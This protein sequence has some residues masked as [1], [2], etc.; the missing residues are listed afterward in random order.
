MI[1]NR[2]SPASPVCAAQG[3]HGE[4]IIVQGNGVKP[5]RW[6]G[7][8]VA[9]DAGVI[10]P[11][12][13]LDVA[14]DSVP[15]GM[16]EGD[17]P[18]PVKPTPGRSEVPESPGTL[19]RITVDGKRHYYVARTDVYKAGNV[20]YGPPELTYSTSEPI[21]NG[22]GR[23]AE[24]KAF[25]NQSSLSE[26]RVDDGGKYYPVAPSI[27]LSDTHGKNAVLKAILDAPEQIEDPAN[28]R[29]TGITGYSE[30]SST[31]W[32]DEATYIEADK[33]RYG[34][35]KFVDIPLE[36]G[37]HQIMGPSF[38]YSVE[39]GCVDRD[40]NP[41]Y[42]WFQIAAQ[43]SVTISGI[44]E[45]R[46]A[47]LRVNAIGWAYNG[48]TCDE[49]RYNRT[50]GCSSSC[51]FYYYLASGAGS[52]VAKKFGAGYNAEDDIIIRIHGIATFDAQ[53]G[54]WERPSPPEKDIVIRA[55]QGTDP[56]NPSGEPYPL[57]EIRID[58]PGEGFLVTPDLE[59][60]SQ[61]GFGAYATCEVADGRITKVTLENPGGGY[62][63]RPEVRILAGGAEAFA[64]ARPHLRGKYQCYYRYVDATPEEKAGPIPSSLSPVVEV[65]AGEGATSLTWNV[66]TPVGRAKKVELWRSTSNQALTLYRVATI[67]SNQHLDDLTDEELRD[68]DREEY[69]AMPFVLPNGEINAMR[70]TPPPSDKAA[71]VRFQ[72]RHWY[73]VDT[74]GKARNSIL[75]SEVDEPES[76]PEENEIVLQQNS[77]DADSVSAL[78]PYGPTLLIMQTRHAYSLSFSSQPLIDAQ[79]TP[80]AYRGCLNQRS[81]EIY[82]GVCYALDQSGIYA[83][84]PGGQVEPISDAIDDL[85][86]TKIDS[87]AFKWSFLSVDPATKTLRAF[88]AFTAD[89]AGAFPSAAICYSLETKTWWLER[90]PQRLT[91]GTNVRLSNG[92]FRCVYGGTGGGYLL[93]SG[94]GDAARGSVETVTLTQKGSGYRTPPAVTAAGGVGA[95]FEASIDGEG[96]LSA[97]WVKSA[98]FG[99]ESGD[100]VIAPPD[101]PMHPDPVQ[102][103]ATYT[104][105]SLVTD[106]PMFPV[107]RFKTGNVPYP[108]DQEDQR[109]GGD[110]D[111][112]VQVTYQP[113]PTTCVTSMRTYYNNSQ[114]PRVNASVRDRG[115][116]FVADLV[117]SASRL[118]FARNTQEYLADSGVATAEFSGR[119]LGDI[120]STDRHVAVEFVGASTSSTPVVIYDLK[121]LGAG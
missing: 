108:T 118:D 67:G 87:S 43:A 91:A 26:I 15:D 77:R 48:A 121:L 115:T 95:E 29:E 11:D 117:D 107:Y 36:N 72:D 88:V 96:R 51:N 111:K 100:L 22:R 53:R 6:D 65:D 16:E 98:G 47:L 32:E 112:S 30:L 103:E 34:I 40:G 44:T 54:I 62:R 55:Y 56:T 18:H 86:K 52:L 97:I 78:I 102:A 2:F 13:P 105:T 92:D 82:D 99:Y 70:F 10:A 8:G 84:T 63:T 31:P 73:G 17:L 60:I 106:T 104:A 101:D 85:F 4:L 57:R 33:T 74:S 90:Y 89:N 76:V 110:V 45:G 20:Y 68:E 120:R 94:P 24:A 23:E 59:I 80:I 81:W 42:T 7:D 64:V 61:S 9:V 19:G 79:V 39:N 46:G 83:I 114:Y 12:L 3:R 109:L 113:Q 38:W 119:S 50:G 25:L 28:S 93:D 75:F 49:P 21:T 14:Y 71:V 66:P 37:D 58:S 116:G 41:K 27:K 69:A 5:A 1:T 35:F